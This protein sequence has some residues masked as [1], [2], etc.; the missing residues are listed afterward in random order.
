MR[1]R[2]K[3]T[4]RK[5]LKTRGWRQKDYG[6]GQGKVMRGEQE[7]GRQEKKFGVRGKKGWKEEDRKVKMNIVLCVISE[8]FMTRK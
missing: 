7:D 2:G 1:D 4:M 8:S 3:K 5:R 6:E